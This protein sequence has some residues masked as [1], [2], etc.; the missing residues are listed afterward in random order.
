MFRYISLGSLGVFFS[1]GSTVLL[2]LTLNIFFS[3]IGCAEGI[4]ERF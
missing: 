3:L 2:N 1:S 4:H